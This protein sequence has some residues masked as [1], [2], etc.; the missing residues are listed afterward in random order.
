MR[1]KKALVAVDMQNDFCL[2]GALAVPEGGT[3]I[4]IL[5]KYIEFFSK[6]GLPIFASRDW[7]PKKT[8]HFKKFG[9]RWPAHC[10]QNT[11]GAEFHSK[12]RLPKEVIVISKGMDPDKESYSV[13]D[14]ADS[15]DTPFINLLKIFGIKEL[16]IGGLATDYCV[17]HSALDALKDGFRVNILVDAI[18]GVNIEPGDSERAIKEM[19]VS[20]AKKLTLEKLKK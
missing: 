13:F 2:G 4:K 1:L 11:R 16:Y 8:R 19:L 12:L 14:G 9:G 3:I 10:I 17:R 7:H 15:N 5:N 20:G 18:K 6:N